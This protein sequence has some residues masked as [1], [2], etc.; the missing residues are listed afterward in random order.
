MLRPRLRIIADE[1]LTGASREA[2]QTRLDLWLANHIERLLGPLFALAAAEDITGIARGVAYQLIE[3]L[4]V[5][6]RQKV[7]EDV[8]GLD[9][10]SRATLRKYGVRFGAYH[11]YMPALLKPAPRS[12]AAQLWTLKHGS[13]DDKGLDELQRLA[14]SGRTSIPVDKDTPKPLYRT[15]G[16]RVCGERAMRVDILERL[17][18]LIRP[19]LAWREGVDRRE[20][21]G[22]VQRLRLHRHRRDDVAHRR[23]GRGLRLDPALARLS[24]GEAAEAAGAGT[25]GD[26]GGAGSHGRAGRRWRCGGS[27]L[28]KLHPTTPAADGR[29]RSDAGAGR[30]ACEDTAIEP[31]AQAS[32]AETGA[33]ADSRGGAAACNRSRC[34]RASNLPALKP[35]AAP[36][37]AAAATPAEPE[38]IEVWRPGR[39]QGER[40]PRDGERRGRRRRH[41]ERP[42]KAGRR[43]APPASAGGR[44]DRRPGR[45]RGRHAASR[46]RAQGTSRPPRHRRRDRGE[47]K[48]ADGKVAEGQ[49]SKPNQR[50]QV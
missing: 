25:G 23:V 28:R 42:G 33:A 16:Y 29:A 30:R 37:E 22:R 13:P 48:D 40:R 11:L 47:R 20:A 41:H 44:G 39:P 10:P 1:Q 46:R 18:D 26:I 8:K 45:R 27:R 35:R 32:A 31:A 4:G 14:S 19:A 43:P 9:Q 3:A 24:H 2:V 7:A 38:M 34:R 36:A 17:A 15:I 6:E 5:L 12:L 21:G 50:K 49:P